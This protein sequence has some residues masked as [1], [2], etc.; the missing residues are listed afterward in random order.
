MVQRVE[1]I[2]L[3]TNFPIGPVNVY[4]L[5]GEKLTLVDAG[6][7]TEQAWKELNDGL[8]NLGL[9]LNDIEQ[10]VLT[11]HH[12]DH[13]GLLEWILEKNPVPVYAH[14]NTE[15]YLCDEDYMYW[16][17]EFFEKLFYEFGL[18]AEMAKKW[19]YRKRDRDL[20]VGL[21]IN[22]GL[23]EG[24][25]IPG[26][27]GWEVIETLGHSQDHISLY[28]AKEKIFICGDHV[29]DGIHAGIFLDAPFRGKK[30]AKPL[31]QYMENL[32]K[33][34]SLP[35]QI[36]YSGHGPDIYNLRDV[37]YTQ[38]ERTEKRA[39][40]V[41]SVLAKASGTGLDIIKEMYPDRY[42]KGVIT[43]VFEI[44]SVLDLLQE[45]HEITAEKKNGIYVYSL[46]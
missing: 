18:T 29:I 42:K 3:T 14:K 32:E 31:L 40:R 39:N 46:L 16:C 37:I 10:I 35:A 23:Q 45:R 7:K 13:M 30:R 27:P 22:K 5:F 9:T 17:G 43:F 2:E 12:N 11:H 6:L 25:E 34:V 26:L 15:T 8:H 44:T 38:F 36:T 1:K 19:A 21:K 4:L 28:Y 41:K 20:L 33:C 24:D